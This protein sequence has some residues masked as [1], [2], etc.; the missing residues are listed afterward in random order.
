MSEGAER[1][2]SL[3]CICCATASKNSAISRRA[4]LAS[5]VASLSLNAV[6]LS[7]SAQTVAND[8]QRID[9]HHHFAPTFHR[10]ALGSRRA[11]T[12]PKWSPSMSI[13]DMDRSGIAISILSPVQPGAWLDNIE[14]SRGLTRRLIEYGLDTLK[15]DGVALMT[16]YGSTYLGDASFAPVYAELNRRAALVY[17]HPKTPQCCADWSRAF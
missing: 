16:S 5:S 11:G 10:D 14:E 13:E 3:R 1:Q 17:V 15:A 7:A 8:D 12:W 4:F 9:V 2:L 6:G